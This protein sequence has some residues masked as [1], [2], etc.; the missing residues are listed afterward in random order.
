MRGECR[1][2]RVRHG[3]GAAAHRVTRSCRR[4]N[5]VSTART[6]RS[7]WSTTAARESRLRARSSVRDASHDRAARSR[8]RFAGEGSES[9]SRG[10]ARRSRRSHHRRRASCVTR[11]ARD[12]APGV[13]VGRSSGDHES[14]IS[15]R[16][17]VPHGRRKR[18][19]TTSMSR[20][21]C[22][23]VPDGK[24]TVT[25][26]SPSAV[27][28]CRRAAA[29]ST[30]WARAA[31]CSCRSSSGANLADSTSGSRFPVEVS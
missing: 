28:P 31:R 9:R 6:T 20:T 5:K 24:R 13:Q 15:P 22:W 30:R 29:G 3:E 14:R 26:C 12:V 18:S 10:S 8:T 11:F 27:W 1:R 19:G 7:S 23:R 2:R 21:S 16:R 25:G 4:I 17:V